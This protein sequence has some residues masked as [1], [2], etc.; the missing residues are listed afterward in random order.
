VRL[1]SG[2]GLFSIPG[3][4]FRN[5]FNIEYTEHFNA[6]YGYLRNKLMILR[7]PGFDGLARPGRIGA[8]SETPRFASSLAL[9]VG[10][11]GE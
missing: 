8:P 5:D 10:A 11:G 4:K 2:F 1:P 6:Y 3:G 9:R 7:H